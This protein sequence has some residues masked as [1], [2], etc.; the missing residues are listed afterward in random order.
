VAIPGGQRYRSQ[1]ERALPVERAG[2]FFPP[3]GRPPD[4]RA[5]HGD[6]GDPGG[7]SRLPGA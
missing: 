7:E 4:G 5:E 1:E 3:G 2:V 6:P